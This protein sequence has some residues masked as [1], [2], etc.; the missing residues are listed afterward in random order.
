MLTRA[1]ILIGLFFIQSI[2]ICKIS[3]KKFLSKHVVDTMSK[4]KQLPQ[5]V[6]MQ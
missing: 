2:H 1:T 4:N 6:D 5:I 3:I